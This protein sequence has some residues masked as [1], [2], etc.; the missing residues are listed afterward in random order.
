MNRKPFAR[1]LAMMS[2]IASITSALSGAAAKAAIAGLGSYTSRGHGRQKH[3]GRKVHS[4]PSGKYTGVTNGRREMAR[5][6]RQ[7]RTGILNMESRGTV[8]VAS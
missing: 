3:S 1:A 7:M 8:K 4:A 2:M 6:D 5:R